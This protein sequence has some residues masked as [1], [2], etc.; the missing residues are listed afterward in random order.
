MPVVVTAPIYF[1]G[2]LGVEGYSG[3]RCL[4]RHRP[5]LDSFPFTVYRL[6]AETGR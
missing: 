5:V 1:H 4:A 6:P 2:T 3:Q